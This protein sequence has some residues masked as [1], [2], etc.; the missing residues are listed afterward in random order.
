MFEMVVEKKSFRAILIAMI[1]C[2]G[3]TAL[4]AVTSANLGSE[5]SVFESDEYKA[6]NEIDKIVSATLLKKHIMSAKLCSDEVFIRR[7]YLD[8]TGTLPE[9]EEVSRFLRNNFEN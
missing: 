7:V 4:A 1:L 9:A 3:S 5:A 8:I 2:A 6:A